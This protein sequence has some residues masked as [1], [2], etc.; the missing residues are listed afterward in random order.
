[1]ELQQIDKPQYRRHL[2]MTSIIA[3]AALIVF[4]LAYAQILIQLF[5]DEEGNNFK[6]NLLGVILAV[7]TA[8]M[9]FNLIKFH[10]YLYEVKYVWDLKQLHNKIY[11]KLHHVKK[12]AEEND[13]DALTIINYYYQASKQLYTLDNNTLTMDGLL[14]D[15]ARLERQLENNRLDIKLSDFNL[16]L[17]KKF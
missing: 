14:T 2:N 7:I 8:V 16:D 15:I 11:R 5:A 10:P 17:L 6:L 1:M 12:S 3:V 9:S 13:I 4:A